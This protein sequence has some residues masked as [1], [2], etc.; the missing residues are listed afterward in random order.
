MSKI[1]V[2][3]IAFAATAGIVFAGASVANAAPTIPLDEAPVAT[4]VGD[5]TTTTGS[6]SA[7]T[8]LA[9]T[10]VSISAGKKTD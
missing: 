3:G 8:E 1:R 4:S 9:K 7:I 6:S 10:L 5:D 2:F